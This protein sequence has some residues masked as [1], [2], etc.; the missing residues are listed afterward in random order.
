MR[1]LSEKIACAAAAAI[2]VGVVAIGFSALWWFSTAPAAML[3]NSGNSPEFYA[4]G[5]VFLSG[6]ALFVIGGLAY[7][8]LA[9]WWLWRMIWPR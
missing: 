1:S 5:F 7:C 4:Q 2:V 6:A 3:A 9:C 8:G